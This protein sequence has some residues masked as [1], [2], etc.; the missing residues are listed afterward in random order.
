M[1][2]IKMLLAGAA[3]LAGPQAGHVGGHVPHDRLGERA[4]L[5]GGADE[6]RAGEA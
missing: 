4:R 5:G 6:S 1:R 3:G 2:T